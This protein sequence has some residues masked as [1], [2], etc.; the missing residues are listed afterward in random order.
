MLQQ[1]EA[2][3]GGRAESPF[4]GRI[5]TVLRGRDR[6]VWGDGRPKWP[7]SL[8]G[9]EVPSSDSPR[10]KNAPPPLG[11]RLGHFGET[12]RALWGDA[13]GTLGRRLG[14]FGETPR[15]LWGDASGTL[16]RR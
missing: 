7:T 5:L 16:G 3:R 9:D 4:R 8:W 15:A 13:S 6:P 2:S 11:R 10:R 12:P 14:H 1:G